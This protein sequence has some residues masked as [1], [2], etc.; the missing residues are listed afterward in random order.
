[1][2]PLLRVNVLC[3]FEGNVISMQSTL[4][5]AIADCNENDKSFGRGVSYIPY[6]TINLLIRRFPVSFPLTYN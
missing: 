5:S 3:P 4:V 1:M 2:E 6:I